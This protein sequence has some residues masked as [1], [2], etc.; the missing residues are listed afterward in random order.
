MVGRSVQTI[1]RSG[2]LTTLSDGVSNHF[3]VGRCLVPLS[4][5]SAQMRRWS[6]YLIIVLPV[7]VSDYSVDRCLIARLVGR[8]VHIISWFVGRSI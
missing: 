1:C 4:V 8:S 2:Y 6:V 7:G 5:W 3:A